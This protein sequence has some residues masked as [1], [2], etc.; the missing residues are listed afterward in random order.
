M[1]PSTGEGFPLVVQEAMAC[2][3]PAVIS[4]D[5]AQGCP[6]VERVIPVCELTSTAWVEQIHRLLSAT[7]DWDSH[8]RQAAEFA[9]NTWNWDRCIRSYADLFRQLA[10]GSS[11]REAADCAARSPEQIS[12]TASP[13]IADHDTQIAA[14]W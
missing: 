5:T 11:V 6:G 1:L 8:R 3:T 13:K 2:G 7:E 12:T 4:D 10:P 14:S 9:Q